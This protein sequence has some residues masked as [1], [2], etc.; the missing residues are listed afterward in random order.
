MFNRRIIYEMDIETHF[1]P[2]NQMQSILNKIQ[3]HSRYNRQS[4]DT[5]TMDQD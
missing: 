3:L 5:V 1:D 4:N 2:G